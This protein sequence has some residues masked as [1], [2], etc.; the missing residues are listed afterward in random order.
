FSFLYKDN[1]LFKLAEHLFV[2]TS[3]GYSIAITWHQAV[4]PKIITPMKRLITTIRTASG[5]SIFSIPELYYIFPIVLGILMFTRFS[6]RH[7]WLSRWPIAFV[8]G[9]G[10]GV[11]VPLSLQNYVFKQME[12]TVTI[13]LTISNIILIIGVFTTLFYFFFSIAHR[14][15]VGGVARIGVYFIMVAFGAGFGYTVMARVSL[16]IGRI[17]FL[18]H[19]WLGLIP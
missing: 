3:V 17:Q 6:R 1:P 13:D 18:L 7:A 12:G 19:D 5:T 8:I 9:F 14:G 11:G 2:G 4:L 10:S 15:K 16:L